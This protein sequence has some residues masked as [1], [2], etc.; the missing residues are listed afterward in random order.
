MKKLTLKQK[1][2]CEHYVKSGNATEAALKAGYKENFA[3]NRIH[4]M[5]KNVGICGYIEEL[6]KHIKNDRIA[7]IIEIKEFWSNI[8]RNEDYKMPDRIKASELIAKTEGA[9]IDK[10]E[11]KGDVGVNPFAGL[12]TDELKKLIMNEK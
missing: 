8:V 9:F 6:N 10:V 3:K 4:T 12:S 2:F 7:D 1:M 11:L 5:M